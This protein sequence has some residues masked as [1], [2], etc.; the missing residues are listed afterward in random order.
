MPRTGGPASKYGNRYEDR[1]TA[2]CALAVLAGNA[3]SIH[4][5]GPNSDIGFEFSLETETGT[6]YHQVKRQRAREGRWTLAALAQ[7]G[8][9]RSF[10]ERLNVPDAV[11]VFASTNSAPA[12]DE[13]ANMAKNASDLAQFEA[14]LESSLPTKGDFETLCE[15]WEADRAWSW[16]ALRRMRLATSGE[17]E[18]ADRLALQTE[19]YLDGPSEAAPAALIEVLRDR[20]DQRLEAADL[21]GALEPYGIRPRK[22]D[23][24]SKRAEVRRL[25]ERFRRTRQAT[26]I[27]GRLIEREESAKIEEALGEERIVFV[28][29]RAGAGKSDVLLGLC[30]RLQAAGTPYLAIRLD[31]QDPAVTAQRLG[32]GLGLSGSPAAVL[33]AASTAGSP[34]CLIVDQLDALSTTSGRNPRFFEAVA[35]TLDLALSQDA[36]TVVLSCRSFDAEN[37]PRLRRL[38]IADGRD[39]PHEVEVG[40]LPAETVKTS[41]EQ[42][43]IDARRI[44]AEVLELLRLPIHLSLLTEIASAGKL[45]SSELRNLHDLYEAYW[46]AKMGEVEEIVGGEGRWSEALDSL[47]DQM[48][49]EQALAAPAASLDRWARE[50]EALVSAGVLVAD[51][52]RLAF[53]HETFFDYVFARRF[54]GRG[55]TIEQLLSTDQFLF[56]RAQVRQVLDYSRRAAPELYTRSLAYLLEEDSV[57]FHLKDL[58]VGW[59][60]GVADPQESEWQLLEPALT[61]PGHPLHDRAWS[62]VTSPAWFRLVDSSGRLA[63]WLADE[64][65]RERGL[66]SLTSAA[67]A[68]PGRVAEILTPRL[69]EEEWQGQIGTLLTRVDLGDRRLVELLLVLIRTGGNTEGTFWFGVAGLVEEHPD[70]FCEILGTY[71]QERLAAAQEAGVANPFERGAGIIPGDLHI[72]QEI[73][74]AARRAPGAFVEYVWPVIVAMVEGAVSEHQWERGGLLQDDIWTHRHFGGAHDLED[75]LLIGGEEA[76]SEL[77]KRD[78]ERFRELLARH[79]KSEM[80]S[81]VYFLFRGLS[82]S[83]DEF[84]DTAVDFL[85]ADPR[86][87]EVGYSDGRH[88][89]TRKLLEAVTPAASE[90]ALGRLEPLLLDYYTPWERSAN[91]HKQFGLTQFTL[92][93]GV[94]PDRR[95]SKMQKRFRELQRKFELEDGP[96][97]FGIQGGMVG[98]PIEPT[99]A[100]KMS[101][102][103]WLTAIATYADDDFDHRRDFLKGG[104]RQLAS[105]LESEA[106]ADP[107]R[108]SR[109]AQAMPPEANVAYYEAILRG[110]GAS[111]EAVPLEVAAEL[112]TRTHELPGRPCG[113][114]ISNPLRQFAEQGVPDEL[115]EILGWYA[116]EGEAESAIGGGQ[117]PDRR[118]RHMRG[119]NSVRGGVAHD[120]ARFVAASAENVG[121]LRPAIESLLADPNTGVREMAL[122]IPVAELRHDEPL[123][124]DWFLRGIEGID[125]VVLDSFGAHEFLRYR[126]TRYFKALGPVIARMV[127]SDD[128][129]VR[130]AGA[131]QAA[132]A[133]LDEPDALVLLERCLAGKADL[134]LGVARVLAAN[135]VNARYRG[136]CE[137]RLVDLFNDPDEKVRK[138]AGKAIRHLRSGGLSDVESLARRYLD[139]QAF[140][141]DPEAIAFAIEGDEMAPIDLSMA[142]VE[143]ILRRL[144]TPEDLRTRDSLIAAEINGIL[145]KIYTGARDAT[146]RNR[147]L[148]LFDAALQAN[149]YG[150]ERELAKYDRG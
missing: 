54:I 122:E 129:G 113:R 51:E 115:L 105:I 107:V 70:W 143:A 95:T 97:P 34:A 139:T 150:A 91:G 29:G 141:E 48:S 80:E 90:D 93:G 104:A 15:I 89:A 85:T 5:E 52:G 42:S 72:D 140:D 134:R 76:M 75:H 43:G 100:K 144:E 30:K 116:I 112:V 9:L 87:L 11:C 46:S 145:M 38:A 118:E 25:N 78:P 114:W 13:L 68:A 12:L 23:Q 82:G 4:L 50:R 99:K 142:A 14:L 96:P 59:M 135:V 136:L 133:A 61:D 8:V 57:R 62:T 55:R 71:L 132:L 20:V 31:R 119:L 84:A 106:E 35:E 26:L 110:V 124:L 27:A 37:D 81:I 65:R 53:F 98:S 126:A 67:T 40:P 66:I 121:A 58:V 128:S 120:I 102:S 47:V 123:A 17:S 39:E 109:L 49:D 74:E 103:N 1:W 32:E 44:E 41:L 10:R 7:V 2:S 6:E 130:S 24:E 69:D 131:S 88:W 56:R 28:H 18:L 101:D 111:E 19:L 77:A 148:D 86:R 16:E 22:G 83:P 137:D 147:A 92:L 108:F 125:E 94:A 21:R 60:G 127:S 33:A 63:D 79:S 73:H 138:E 45:R 149:S 3:T 36:M 64:G 117:D 146:L